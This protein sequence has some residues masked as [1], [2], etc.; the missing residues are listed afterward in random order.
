MNKE[1][2][3]TSA[4]SVGRLDTLRENVQNAKES[5]GNCFLNDL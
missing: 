3:K 4:L 2:G 1:E 5:I